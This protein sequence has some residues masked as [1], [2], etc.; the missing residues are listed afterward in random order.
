MSETQTTDSVLLTQL[1]QALEQLPYLS[2]LW[3]GYSGGVDSHVLLH[4]LHQLVHTKNIALSLQAIHVHHGISSN[5][6]HWQ[7]HC[8][9]VCEALKIPLTV[10]RVCVDSESGDGLEAAARDARYQ[11]F[12]QVLGDGRILALAHHQQDQAE[13]LLY[14]LFRGTGI[15]GLKG[16]RVLAYRKGLTLFRPLLGL[17][18]DTILEYAR[19]HQLKWIEDESNQDLT[20]QRNYIR[21]Q[22]LPTIQKQWPQVERTLSRLANLA[23]ETSTIVD[24]VAKIDWDDCSHPQDKTLDLA[25]LFQLPLARQKALIRFWC[26]QHQCELPSEAQ[27][28]TILDVFAS[29]DE[30]KQPE[31]C[32]G[33]VRVRRYLDR[34]WLLQNLP[35]FDATDQ[36]SWTEPENI[37]LISGGQLQVESTQGKGLATKYFQNHRITIRYRQGSEKIRRPKRQHSEKIKNLMQTYLVPPW[38]RPRLPLVYVDDCLAYIPSIGVA[39]EFAAQENEEGALLSWDLL[40]AFSNN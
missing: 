35:D 15:E 4:A 31:V 2:R 26:Q 12:Q 19:E 36:L 22:V 3:I 30:D 25:C 8:E 11:G 20:L 38:L 6:D 10:Q 28:N 37:A 14:R 39:E 16:M 40:D 1:E 24:T 34:L 9:Q 13:T 17:S 23:D 29:A 7:S 18:K 33:E 5:A 32:W 21:H 27:L